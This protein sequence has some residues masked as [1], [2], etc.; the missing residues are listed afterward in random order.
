MSMS[1]E[2]AK[3]TLGSC[4]V[5]FGGII[6]ALS[7]I[8]QSTASDTQKVTELHTLLLILQEG[9]PTLLEAAQVVLQYAAAPQPPT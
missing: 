6:S 8:E 1:L 3:E 4:I 7:A 2:D 5:Q 9:W